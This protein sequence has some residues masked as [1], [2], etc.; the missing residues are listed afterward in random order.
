MT[1]NEKF[2]SDIKKIVKN[3][4]NEDG[5]LNLEVCAEKIIN[6]FIRESTV[7]ESLAG[8]VAAYWKSEYI[9]RSLE[10]ENE[11]TQEHIEILC[12]F[13]SFLENSDENY[14]LISDSDW[15]E[16]CTL[17]DCEAENLSIEVLQQLMSVLVE[18]NAF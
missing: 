9:D 3:E 6:F 18:K 1:S 15:K 17:V 5:T 2:Y 14:D 10:I 11:P 16:L 13:L 12:A 4:R 8:S 7:P